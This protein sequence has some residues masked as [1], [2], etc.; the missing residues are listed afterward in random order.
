MFFRGGGGMNSKHL[1]RFSK[2]EKGEGEEKKE[3]RE[4]KG[5]GKGKGKGEGGGKKGRNGRNWGKRSGK[6]M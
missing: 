4:R 3:K 1:G 2:G 5:K 6:W